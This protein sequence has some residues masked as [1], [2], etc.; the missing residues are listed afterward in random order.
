MWG[1]VFI[2]SSSTGFSME[3]IGDAQ[4]STIG[5]QNVDTVLSPVNNLSTGVTRGIN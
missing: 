3:F 5:R 1:I 4:D 2:E